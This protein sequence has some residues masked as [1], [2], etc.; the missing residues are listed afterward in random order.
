MKP[1]RHC[2]RVAVRGRLAKL[3]HRA[4]VIFQFEGRFAFL[5]PRMHGTVDQDQG[6]G[7]GKEI[8]HILSMPNG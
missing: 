2:A 6:N 7:E 1:S 4:V 8:R 3:P 5:V